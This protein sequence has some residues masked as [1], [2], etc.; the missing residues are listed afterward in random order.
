MFALAP[1]GIITCDLFDRF[2]L[3]LCPGFPSLFFSMGS[4]LF[5]FVSFGVL[6]DGTGNVKRLAPPP[7]GACSTRIRCAIGQNAEHD[8]F[9][10]SG[11][12]P[13]LSDF[14]R[15]Y[16]VIAIVAYFWSPR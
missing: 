3:F 12:I 9:S 10:F 5:C 11:F 1:S 6:F 8:G 7:L 2:G 14:T 4:F 13:S 16:N 15:Y